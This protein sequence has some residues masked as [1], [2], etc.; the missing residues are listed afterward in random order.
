MSKL[1][2]D[3]ILLVEGDDDERFVRS[4]LKK[5]FRIEP[6]DI[7]KYQNLTTNKIKKIVKDLNDS[8]TPYLVLADRDVTGCLVARKTSKTEKFG[9]KKG[10]VAI[11]DTHIESWYVAGATNKKFI[12]L[13]PDRTTKTTFEEIV[14]PERR[15][16][17]QIEILKSY[18]TIVAKRKSKSFA[19]FYKKIC[20]ILKNYSYR[21]YGKK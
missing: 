2:S 17:A 12:K 19:Y 14:S 11:A 21:S 15:S 10:H 4:I 8:N 5:C 3:L 1:N 20:F 6:C 7:L 9:T 13:D 16:D 18:N